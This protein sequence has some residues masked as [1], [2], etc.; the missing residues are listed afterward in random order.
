[1]NKHN[2]V[3]LLN[4]ISYSTFI[5]LERTSI[6][7]HQQGRK[8]T[9]VS[10][11]LLSSHKAAMKNDIDTD[12]SDNKE[13]SYV[14]AHIARRLKQKKKEQRKYRKRAIRKSSSQH[15]G[16][17]PNEERSA[18]PSKKSVS[19]QEDIH[20]ETESL[21]SPHDESRNGELEDQRHDAADTEGKR[22]DFFSEL[23]NIRELSPTLESY[24]CDALRAANLIADE[25]DNESDDDY[26]KNSRAYS[27]G[28]VSSCY[29]SRQDS[30]YE[31]ETC[32][33]QDTTLPTDN[34]AKLPVESR[35]CISAVTEK[36][37]IPPGRMGVVIVDSKQGPLVTA[38]A[39][40][41]PVN[42]M[43]GDVIA[44]VDGRDTSTLNAEQ[45]LHLLL[46]RSDQHRFLLVMR[47]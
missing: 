12:P 1:M 21:V 7:F 25:S 36:I 43:V 10:S 15:P 6:E 44:S 17:P 34:H 3:P 32:F 22:E 19:F 45:V 29:Y 47:M 40:S 46:A 42:L 9:A 26:E 2:S 13:V 8:P 31:D 27:D 20:V 28:D 16:C 35:L 37:I 38:V 18:R 5:R 11:L 14:Y 30:T 39:E 23:P 41:C 4:V 24:V 33:S